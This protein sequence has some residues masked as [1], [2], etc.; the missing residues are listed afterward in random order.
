[1]KAKE[2][3]MTTEKILENLK[4]VGEFDAIRQNYYVYEGEKVF[5]LQSISIAKAHGGNISILP[6]GAVEY[7]AESF[8]GKQ[9]ITAGD[10]FKASTHHALI[11][12]RFDA[13]NVLYVLC[14]Q[15]RANRDNRFNPPSLHF[16]VKSG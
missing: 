5:I 10:V 8:A 13:L 15:G 14:A 6:K 2:R 9:N 1:M 12:T 3:Y 7:V 4:F 11:R 16:N